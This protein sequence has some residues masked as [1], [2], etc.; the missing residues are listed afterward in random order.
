VKKD[1]NVEPKAMKDN[2]DFARRD[3]TKAIGRFGI[4]Y[5][6]ENIATPTIRKAFVML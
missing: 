4:K 1:K 5:N 2:D 6:E 3:A